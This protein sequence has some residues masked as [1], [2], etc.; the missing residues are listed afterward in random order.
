MAQ[1][2]ICSNATQ[3][4]SMR[5]QI[6]SVFI[7]SECIGIGMEQENEPVLKLWEKKAFSTVHGLL[8][9]PVSAINPYRVGLHR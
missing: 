8:N 3:W 6:T 1:S 9:T 7:G 4:K 5:S 2:I